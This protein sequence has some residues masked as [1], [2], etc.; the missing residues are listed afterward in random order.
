MTIRINGTE[1]KLKS[2]S[3]SVINDGTIKIAVLLYRQ[4]NEQ[5]FSA[6]ID[7]SKAFNKIMVLKDA[8]GREHGLIGLIKDK[9]NSQVMDWIFNTSE[10]AAPFIKNKI[11]DEKFKVKTY[12]LSKKKEPKPLFLVLQKEFFDKI[13]A[14]TKTT[15]YRDHKSFYTSRLMRDGEYRNFDTVI[16]QEGYN[17]DARRMT[18]KIERIRLYNGLFEI[19]LGEIIERNF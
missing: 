9:I 17:K 5:D 19:D 13:I 16:F 7:D 8:S 14:G 12:E 18:V 2:L 4:G 11:P 3:H 6:T 10:T 15:E 1:F